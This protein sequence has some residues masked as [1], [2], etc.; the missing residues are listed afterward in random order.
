MLWGEGPLAAFATIGGGTLVIGGTRGVILLAPGGLAITEVA[1]K[2]SWNR[3]RMSL[4][5]EI[6]S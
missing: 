5:M 4:P 2:W 6:A 1:G 3:Q